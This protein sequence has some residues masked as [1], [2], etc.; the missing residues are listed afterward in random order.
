MKMIDQSRAVLHTFHK[1]FRSLLMPAL[2]LALGLLVGAS[3]S[4]GANLTWTNA[5]TP[6]I[7]QNPLAWV[8]NG[9]SSNSISG[10]TTSLV[11]YVNGLLPT[12]T[13]CPDGGT[14]AYPAQSAPQVDGATFTNAGTYT[15]QLT[16]SIV[17]TSNIFANASGTVAAVTLDLGSSQM[18]FGSVGG[19]GLT[20]LNGEAAP[21]L[22]GWPETIRTLVMALAPTRL[23]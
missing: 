8:T 2:L 22:F 5:N 4:Y 21:Q 10:F 3:N 14:G 11:C 1:V 15:V 23:T 12:T 9:S 20:L 19:G 17:I 13:N 7:W 18:Y 6:A 16:G